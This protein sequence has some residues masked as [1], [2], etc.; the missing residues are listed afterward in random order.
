M[1]HDEMQYSLCIP[2][3]NYTAVTLNECTQRNQAKMHDLTGPKMNTDIPLE[4]HAS[5]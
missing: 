2:I 1:E 3:K 4:S 5:V